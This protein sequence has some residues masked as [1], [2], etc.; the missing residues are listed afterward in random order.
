MPSQFKS[1]MKFPPQDSTKRLDQYNKIKALYKNDRS[2]WIQISDHTDS[3]VRLRHDAAGDPQTGKYLSDLSSAL[4]KKDTGRKRFISFNPMKLITSKMAQL[5]FNK[6]V[7][8]AN[9]KGEPETEYAIRRII[10]DNKLNKTGNKAVTDL[11]LWGDFFGRLRVGSHSSYKDKEPMVFVDRINPRYCFPVYD[12]D[13]MS[14]C[15][16]IHPGKAEGTEKKPVL[17][18]NHTPGSIEYSGFY[19]DSETLSEEIPFGEQIWQSLWPNIP[20][21]VIDTQVD[22]LLVWHVA[23][24]QLEG[25]FGETRF[26]P[27]LELIADIGKKIGGLSHVHD[28]AASPKLRIPES[29]ISRP[30]GSADMEVFVR[31]VIPIFPDTE[32]GAIGWTEIVGSSMTITSDYINGLLDKICFL[33]SVPRSLL[34]NTEG[35]VE[36][37]VAIIN[38]SLSAFLESQSMIGDIKNIFSEMLYYVQLIENK[39]GLVVETKIEDQDETGNEIEEVIYKKANYT[40]SI[41]VIDIQFS[42]GNE[43]NVQNTIAKLNAGLISKAD[44][45]TEANPDAEP[46]DVAEKIEEIEEEQSQLPTNKARNAMLNNFT[47]EAN[48]GN[49]RSLNGEQFDQTNALTAAIAT[50]QDTGVNQ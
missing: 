6:P 28:V 8:I 5:I 50:A 49:T 48:G 41:P 37:G 32:S 15:A 12:S 22:R 47:Q 39:I 38:K 9:I 4:D 19:M 7:R 34:F 45:Y 25:N 10:R 18:E 35:S 26:D 44:A 42:V 31:D 24:G 21:Q 40:A 13:E 29:M 16:I 30:D 46:A 1:G 43:P 11:W 3:G 27:V 14:S 33:I 2:L 36:S 17:I 23:Q 20:Q